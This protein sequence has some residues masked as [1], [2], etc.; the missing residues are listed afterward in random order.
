MFEVSDE[1]EHTF[2]HAR[3]VKWTC[4]GAVA[5]IEKMR[6]YL[7]LPVRGWK[8]KKLASFS[9]T[10]EAAV[11]YKFCSISTTLARAVQRYPDN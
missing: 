10:K 11:H 3:L 2:T 9:T 1:L 4:D 6:W 8:D 5:E 7:E